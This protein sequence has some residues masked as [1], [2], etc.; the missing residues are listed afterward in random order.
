MAA[1]DPA[2][3]E[4]GRLAIEDLSASLAREMAAAADQSARGEVS[5][6]SAA[7]AIGEWAELLSRFWPA[8]GESAARGS[9]DDT[10]KAHETSDELNDHAPSYPLLS[11]E[12]SGS[13]QHLGRFEIRRALGHGGFGIVFLVFD[14]RLNREAALKIPRPE[15]MVSPALRQRFLREAQAAAVLDHPNIVPIYDT[16]ELGPVGYILSA[17]CKGPTLAH[18]L[19]D[20]PGSVAPKV[21]AQVVSK[22]ADAVHHA[23]S[24][25]ILHRDIKPA[26][27]LLEPVTEPHS[28]RLPFAPRLSDFGLAKRLDEVTGDTRAGMI[29]G[30][31]QYM[32]PEQAAGEYRDVGIQTDVYSLGVVLYE[33]L[34]GRTPFVGRTDSQTLRMIAEHDLSP[35]ALRARQVPRD[36][37]T[38]CLKCL[39]IEQ[40]ARY[41][42]AGDL[43]DDLRRFLAGEVVAARPIR[44]GERFVR[45]CRRNSVVAALAAT[46]LLAMVGGTGISTYYAL[47]AGARASEAETERA[48]AQNALEQARKA[49]DDSFTVLSEQTLLNEP[50]MQPLRKELLRTALK[51]Y[52]DFVREQ[53]GDPSLQAELARAHVRAGDIH[54]VIGE[55]SEAEAQFRKAIEIRER[56]ARENPA[57]TD[58]RRDLADG[59][60]S[61]ANW[62]N[63][64]RRGA[65]TEPLF[66]K[67]IEIRE[68]LSRENPTVADFQSDLAAGYQSLAGLKTIMR[69][70]A[71]AETLLRKV[72]AIRERLVRENPTVNGYR[73]DLAA[74]YHTLAVLQKDAGWRAE[75]EE[76]FGKAIEIHEKLARENPVASVER[77]LAQSY[78]QLAGLQTTTGQQ[79]EAEELFGKAIGI[80]EKLARENPTVVRY[81]RDLADGYNELARVQAATLQ[82]TT[83]ETSYRRAIEIQQRLTREDPSI[84]GYQVQLAEYCWN[85]MVLLHRAGRTTEAREWYGKA[86]DARETLVRDE[87][88]NS[89]YRVSLG[90]SYLRGAEFQAV[91]NY[92]VDAEASYGRAIEVFEQLTHDNPTD[93]DQYVSLAGA[94]NGLAILLAKTGRGEDAQRSYRSAIDASLAKNDDSG[95]RRE[96]QD[97]LALLHARLALQTA[98]ARGGR[99]AV[100]PEVTQATAIAPQNAVVQILC[101]DAAGL[102]GHWREAAES[103]SRADELSGQ[104][105]WTMRFLARL[106]LAADDET[107]YRATCAQLVERHGP[108][109]TP[110]QGC[111]IAVTCVLA[112]HALDD[113]TPVVELA[114]LGIDADPNDPIM[115]T[116]FGGALYRA[117]RL[118]E[119]V[120][121]LGKALPLHQKP[122][123]VGAN[124]HDELRVIRLYATMLLSMAYRDLGRTDKLTAVRTEVVRQVAEMVQLDTPDSARIAPWSFRFAVELAQWEVSKLASSKEATAD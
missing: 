97:T 122:I 25:G 11:R 20:Q 64:A 111:L 89:R 9:L 69:R 23:H 59:Y 99:D 34:T 77:E 117:G 6:A 67:A 86:I 15:I 90:D 63:V 120:E 16:G 110:R 47:A 75:A 21:A 82:S 114:Q 106:L 4:S 74:S 119:A 87:P 55:H 121:V 61:L 29:L 102:A 92:Y 124:Q 73:S 32:A 26:N 43:A 93:F 65:E 51:Y 19:R 2:S 5:S 44:A 3:I 112:D 103:Y 104:G 14:P 113:M 101:G 13:P 76:L 42:S 50:G 27:V 71:E 24:R 49:V 72:A 53:R 105:S 33:L 60:M 107:G 80:H 41:Q 17:Y 8:D 123:A 39:E 46:V 85:L 70:L 68:K 94:F 109:A 91:T 36:L 116:A 58:C 28:G 35:A 78:K 40:L 118:E 38:I 12:D 57:S 31:P 7:R 98:L 66:Q 79:A 62:Q 81:Q 54:A 83:A 88:T 22:L 30:T 48:R 45:W 84:A 1:N 108:M 95:D 100:G 37:E 10:S 115:L 96:R 56:L 52:Q 18:W